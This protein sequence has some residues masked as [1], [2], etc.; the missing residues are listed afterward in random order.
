MKIIIL[1]CLVVIASLIAHADPAPL[2]VP[3]MDLDF[4]NGDI[5]YGNNC[6]NYATNRVTNSFAQPG[7]ASDEMYTDL[8]CEDVYAAAEKDLGLIPAE[9]FKFDKTEDDTLIALVVSPNYDFH[10]YRRDADNMWSHKN[11]STPA[12]NLDESYELISDPETADRGSYTDFCGYFRVKN[13]PTNKDEQNAGQVRIGDM[14]KLP[15]VPEKSEVILSMY[16]GRRNPSFPLADLL[17]DQEL[18]KGLK[19]L[20]KAISSRMKS[21][22]RNTR[23]PRLG[24][25]SL[26]IVDREGL[27]FKKNARVTVNE[28]LSDKDQLLQKNII[29]QLQKRNS[30]KN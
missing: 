28:W 10:W 11:G 20:S 3:K 6:Y 15:A 12:T 22:P 4:W 23:A 21:G 30:V 2:K 5:Q 14:K 8:Q 19:S 27:L 24:E 9:F 16:S 17:K 25:V 26:Q 1:H 7:E 18:A 29:Q 13:Y